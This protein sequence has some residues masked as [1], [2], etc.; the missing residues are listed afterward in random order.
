MNIKKL[1]IIQLMRTF[2]NIQFEGNS[3]QLV[4][5]QGLFSVNFVYFKEEVLFFNLAVSIN[6]YYLLVSMIIALRGWF[7][8]FC[9]H[10]YCFIFS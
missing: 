4:L 7:G 2:H 3:K 6:S 10:V 1:V 8:L 9:Q 5:M